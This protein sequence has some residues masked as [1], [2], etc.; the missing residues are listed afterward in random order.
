MF[1]CVTRIARALSLSLPIFPL[2]VY[3]VV[4]VSFRSLGRLVLLLA[5]ESFRFVYS[6]MAVFFLVLG[7]LTLIDVVLFSFLVSR[8]VLSCGLWSIS[9]SLT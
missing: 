2:C 9:F 5:L 7:L 1:L 6:G 3:S 4:V 8:F